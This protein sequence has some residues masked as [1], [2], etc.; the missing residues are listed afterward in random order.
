MFTYS[1]HRGLRCILL[2]T[3][4]GRPLDHSPQRDPGTGIY[5]HSFD[6]RIQVHTL[7]QDKEGS[8]HSVFIFLFVFVFSIVSNFQRRSYMLHSHGLVCLEGSGSVHS[9]HH[10]WNQGGSNRDSCSLGHSNLLDTLQ[11]AEQADFLENIFQ[12]KFLN[13]QKK[14]VTP[15]YFVWKIETIARHC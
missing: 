13:T 3:H 15:L 7:K 6:P 2:H 11:T 10:I 5:S 8:K 4:T 12:K 14:H 9:V 1:F